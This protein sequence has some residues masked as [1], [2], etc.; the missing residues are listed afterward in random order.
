M[1]AGTNSGVKIGDTFTVTNVAKELVDPAS[2]IV[3]GRIERSLGKIEV[4]S[5]TNLYAV[6]RPMGDF[7]VNRGDLLHR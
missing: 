4:Q 5:V 7:S 1:N 2:G 6:A 3:L